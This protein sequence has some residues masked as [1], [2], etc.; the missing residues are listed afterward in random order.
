M[1]KAILK[2]IEYVVPIGG[3]IVENIKSEE[4]GVGRFVKPRFI[5]SVIKFIV[6]VGMTY[7]FITGKISIDELLQITG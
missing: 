2:V 5:K 4:G 6:A 3:D 1:I 7:M